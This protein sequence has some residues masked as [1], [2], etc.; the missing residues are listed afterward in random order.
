[1]G[2]F[3]II[4]GAAET[5]AGIAIV[6]LVP[7][8]VPLGAMLIASGAGMVFSGVGTLLAG[9]QQAGFFTTERNPIAPWRIIYG[10]S[11]VGGTL[12][13]LQGWE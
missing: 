13:A 12:T 4:L 8:G 5:A 1:M 3:K 6:A 10:R 7:G 2:I 11:R 9:N